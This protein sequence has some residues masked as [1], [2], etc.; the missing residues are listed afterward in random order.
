MVIYAD[1][2]ALIKL[3]LE[4][5]HSSSVRAVLQGTDAVIACSALGRVE[6]VSALKRARLGRRLSGARLLRVQRE[7][8]SAWQ[9]L[10]VVI[11]TEGLILDA[12]EIALRFGLRAYD[13]V[14]L[15]AVMY[16]A[17]QDAEPVIMSFDTELLTAAEASGVECWERW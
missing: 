12:C 17:R 2:S 9:R 3:W 16:L 14:H 10:L 8:A 7:L 4:E 6:M 5:E 11:L 15:A 13:A 1:P